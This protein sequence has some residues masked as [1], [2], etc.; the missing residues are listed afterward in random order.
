[1]TGQPYISVIVTAYNRRRYLP[2][3]LRSLETQT[4][5]RDRFEV[6]VVKNFEDKESDSII[7][8]NGWKDLYEDSTY[9]GRKILVGL[10]ESRGEVITIL[11]DDDVYVSNRLEEVYRA[12]TSYD[13]LVYFHNSQTIIDSNGNV[14]ESPPLFLP[15]SK[16]LVG[17]SPIVI[18]V[19]KLQMLARKY[20]ISTVDITLKIRVR[21]DVNSSSAAVKRDTLEANAHLLKELP[22]GIDLF[23]FASSLKAGGLMYFTDEKLTL[24]RVHGENWSYYAHIARSGSNETRLKRARALI[25]T[26]KAF[27][28]IGSRLLNGNINTYLCFERLNKGALLLL[29]LPE[30]GTLPP[31]LRLSL[32]DVKLALSCYKIGAEDLVDV[33]FVMESALLSPLLASPRGRLVLGK[34]VE[35]VVEALTTKRALRRESLR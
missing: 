31:E 28:L 21:A 4:L 2:F 1:M 20:G 6:I 34:L 29:P 3:A 35:G 11:E 26:I 9:H 18:D 19:N 7:S 14:L 12:F 33:V 17:G 22:I 5:P 30:L 23:I 10:E 8:R 16:N 25:Q 13:R 32:S 15:T 24:Y 27:R